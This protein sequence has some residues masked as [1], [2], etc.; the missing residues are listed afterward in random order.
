VT[1][2]LEQARAYAVRHRWTVAGEHVYVD[3]GISGAEFVRHPGLVALLNAVKP[4]A[5]FQALY[6]RMATGSPVSR[7]RP[8]TS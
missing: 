7:S 5:P 1:R 2:Q 8:L 6:A 4:Q 3:A